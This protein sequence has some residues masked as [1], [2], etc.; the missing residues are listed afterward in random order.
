M[1]QAVSIAF[2][3]AV[4]ARPTVMGALSLIPDERNEAPDG[5]AA[6]VSF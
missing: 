2:A 4:A 6:R 5:S 3:A 1:T